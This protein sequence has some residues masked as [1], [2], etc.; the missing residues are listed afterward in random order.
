MQAEKA[1]QPSFGEAA[2]PLEEA[3][4][5]VDVEASCAT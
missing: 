1:S 3:T 2:E 5:C 4:L